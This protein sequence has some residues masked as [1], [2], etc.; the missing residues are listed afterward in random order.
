MRR[1]LLKNKQSPGDIV[2]LTA[3]VRDLH[4]AHPGQFETWIKTSAMPLWEHNPHA[5][6]GEPDG[7]QGVEVETIECAYAWMWC[8]Q[9]SRS[10][11]SGARQMPPFLTMPCRKPPTA[12]SLI[13]CRAAWT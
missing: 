13:T 6:L 10:C 11:P 4:R 3:A 12:S 8:M 1:L 7:A 5:R 9:G 2:M